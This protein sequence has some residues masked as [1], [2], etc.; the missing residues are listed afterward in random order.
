M[1]A[2]EIRIPE[3]RTKGRVHR[4]RQALAKAVPESLQREAS[5]KTRDSRIS[6]KTLVGRLLCLTV[7]QGGGSEKGGPD[8]N[9]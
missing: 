5:S 7:P 8:H 2:L 9:T 3:S 1:A 4:R 6:S